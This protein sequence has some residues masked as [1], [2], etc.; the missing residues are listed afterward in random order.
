MN[1][2]LLHELS[3]LILPRSSKMVS[4]I[5]KNFEANK[6]VEIGLVGQVSEF[7]ERY[8][9]IESGIVRKDELLEDI[10]FVEVAHV[11]RSKVFYVDKSQSGIEAIPTVLS[12]LQERKLFIVILRNDDQDVFGA[13]FEEN[14]IL[15]ASLTH[16]MALRDIMSSL[17]DEIVEN[18]PQKEDSVI[19]PRIQLMSIDDKVDF[20]YIY[21]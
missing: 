18:K 2:V 6:Q 10:K 7:A 5:R 21:I 12:I 20:L 9:S 19:N 16:L 8:G 1:C 4:E 3:A 11:G 15:V 13:I 14:V 17:E